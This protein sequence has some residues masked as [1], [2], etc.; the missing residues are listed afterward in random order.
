MPL[1]RRRRS[2]SDG[3]TDRGKSGG[4]ADQGD[5]VTEEVLLAAVRWA[6]DLVNTGQLAEAERV[7]RGLV[8]H[9]RALSPSPASFMV[10]RLLGQ[11]TRVAGQFDDA[12][13][14]YVSAFEVASALPDREQALD[15]RVAAITGIAA[16]EIAD[17]HLE[18]AAELFGMATKLA[19]LVTDKTGLVSA[20]SG[21][22]EV[23]H[24]QGMAGAEELYRRALDQPGVDGPRRGILLDNAARELFRQ[25]R[26]DEAIESAAEA[27]R[28]LAD[29]SARYDAY[30]AMINLATLRREVDRDS[31]GE[32]F[33]AAHDLIHDMHSRVDVQHYTAGFR[34]RV[35]RIEA[36][37]RERTDEDLLGLG[38][39]AFQQ[40]IAGLADPRMRRDLALGAPVFLAQRASE[41]GQRHLLEH[42]YGE[43][44][45]SL[46][47]AE[48]FW[49]HLGA[50]HMLPAVWSALGLLY[51][52]VGRY[53]EA[54]ALLQQARR[55]AHEL[56][57]ARA[58]LTASTNLCTLLSRQ[59]TLTELDQLE[60]VAQ[61]RALFD[62][63]AART[64]G[65]TTGDLGILDSIAASLARDY[66]AT[67]L[68]DRYLLASIDAVQRAHERHGA[69][70][71]F[72]GLDR[73]ALR[74][75]T[76]VLNW[77][78]SG[79]AEQAAP[80]RER[81]VTLRREARE[82]A[83]RYPADTAL[84][85][86]A[87]AAGERTEQTLRV[88]R[89]ACDG[90]D[91]LRRGIA[92]LSAAAGFGTLFAPPFVQAASLA[93]ELGRVE[94]AFALLERAKS[95]ALLEALRDHETGAD[96]A[97]PLAARE[98]ALWAELRRLRASGMDDG[99]GPAD[100]EN[101]RQLLASR[102]AAAEAQQ[103]V[104]TELLD[105]W[106]QLAASHP[107]MRAHRMAEPITAGEAAPLL[108]VAGDAVLVEYLTGPAGVWAFTLNGAGLTARQLLGPEV[109]GAPAA[110]DVEGWEDLLV[111]ADSDGMRRL[112]QHPVHAVLTA[113]IAEVPPGR[114]VFLV[115]H[116]ALHLAPLHLLPPAGG[117]ASAGDA[118][119]ADEVGEAGADEI[120]ARPGTYLLP[121]ASLLRVP[122][123]SPAR[124]SPMGT[125]QVDD[126]LDA[127]AAR[128]GGEIVNGVLVAGDPLGDLPYARSECAYVAGRLGG[129]A[130]TGAAVTSAWLAD[131]LTRPQRPRLVHLA[132]HAVFDRRRPERSGLVLAAAPATS[133]AAANGSGGV[134]LG[135][136]LDGDRRRGDP[137]GPGPGL[138][139]FAGAGEV[140]AELVSL[141]RL[142]EWDW[143]GVLVVLSAC[144][145]GRH[146]VRDGDELVGLGRTL[147]AAGAR[148]LV[149][150]IRPVPDLATALLM[151]WFYDE[152]DL[153]G[154]LGPEQ[155]GTVLGQAQR[156]L[157]E[158]TAA[159]LVAR[160][161]QLVTAGGDHALLGC[162]TIAV[163]HRAAGEIESFVTWQRH[164]GTLAE[165]Q[166]LPAGTVH[167]QVSTGAPTYRTVRPFAELADWA[168]FTVY[169]AP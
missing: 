112:V 118:G 21:H 158:A 34:A 80:F 96:P 15:L 53:D 88:L 19:E 39:P 90:Y 97:D 121:S 113:P 75:G 7:L 63:L 6:Q 70:L 66:G 148:A 159:D 25:G 43:A 87:L 119:S 46:R 120:R 157:R 57:D 102:M 168:S 142:A 94:E 41:E 135:R 162:R 29:S 77:S 3:P 78:Y 76:L 5:E 44:E 139:P 1:F 86:A 73:L 99:A 163:A 101:R 71:P 91:E 82:A 160:G 137:V 133:G 122:R 60:L 126:A 62:F 58:E 165:G 106:R 37:T 152:L 109:P 141:A 128:A 114:T 129:A 151:G 9:A 27:V 138:P 115:P 127:C 140:G 28:L 2:G 72:A 33:T 26:R 69:A 51:T 40:M 95:R 103:T 42:R 10:F 18:Q 143:G 23:L 84:G 79:R 47:T 89:D 68:A 22:A 31:A 14:A 150:A 166:P 154:R 45:R 35:E 111:S 105:L 49:T 130:R 93:L 124:T 48:E 145:S 116:G 13:R 153:T 169:G 17:E 98:A 16:V 85:L 164:L 65:E 108:A 147:L 131:A 24:R 81:L 38:H 50:S 30:K 59:P 117:A 52:T 132:C 144:D 100:V 8:G 56:G 167:R 36:A 110:H 136:L 123:P 104:R 11:C 64:P 67:A 83:V 55:T 155:V 4:G 156:R 20:L 149:T 146:E 161:V 107:T 74:L 125:N 32:A 54:L 12:R 134:Q 92:D 61:A